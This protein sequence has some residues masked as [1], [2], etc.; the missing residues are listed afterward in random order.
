MEAAENERFTAHLMWAVREAEQRKYYPKRFKSM[1]NADGGFDTVKRILATGKISDGF[2]ELQILDRIDLTC[3]AIVVESEWRPYFDEELL[4]RAEATLRSVGYSFKRFEE[5]LASTNSPLNR[6]LL[7]T[8]DGNQPSGQDE[9]EADLVAGSDRRINAFFQEV[10]HAPVLNARWSWGAVDERTR[11]VFL[12]VWSKEVV[13]HE[14]ATLYRVLGDASS[15]PGW[16]ERKRHVELI[17]SGYAAFAVLCEKGTQ[18]G[19]LIRT[20]DREKILVLG[21]VHSIDDRLYMDVVDTILVEALVAPGKLPELMEQDLGEL[22]AADIKSTTRTALID[23]RLGQG[24]YRRELLRRW[25]G[26]CAVT[27]CRVG[28]MLRASHCKPWRHSDNR[29][30]LDSN[31]GLVLTAN[32]D[33]LF[34]AGLVSFDD[35]GTMLLAGGLSSQEREALGLPANLLRTPGKELQRFLA[36][37]RDAVFL[38][39]YRGF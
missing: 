15:R 28:A 12:R 9:G 19:A 37:H 33:A 24:R 3:E 18:G 29:E 25:N 21:D 36:F 11:R 17:K 20:F 26:A 5:N 8:L 31:N 30:R 22:H 27:G 32:L 16:S 6:T 39:K 1:I 14:D 2:T 34:D 38:K 4:Q 10:L 7:S 23:A 35:Q 13:N